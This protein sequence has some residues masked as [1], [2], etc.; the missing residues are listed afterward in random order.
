MS[1]DLRPCAVV[2]DSVV[3]LAIA[4][5]LDTPAAHSLRTSRRP[6]LPRTDVAPGLQVSLRNI[7][8]NLLVQR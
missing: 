8:Q 1:A 4:S 7:L 3:S 5:A 6:A 2:A